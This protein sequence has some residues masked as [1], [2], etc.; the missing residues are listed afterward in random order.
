MAFAQYTPVKN[1]IALNSESYIS[2][3]CLT[4]R[5]LHT[6]GHSMGSVCYICEN[7]IFSGDTLF[8]GSIGRTDFPGSNSALMRNSL[9]VL[10]ELPGN[11][12]VYPGHNESTDLN[13]ERSNNPY[14]RT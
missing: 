4:F 5:V 3:G 7:V 12:T 6:P 2:D 9:R 11:Y 8:C 1:Y 10:S 14:L 13:Y